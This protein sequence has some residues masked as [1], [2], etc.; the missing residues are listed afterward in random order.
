MKWN[1][2]RMGL[3]VALAF[4]SAYL[5]AF[6]ADGLRMS[7]RRMHL[8]E[9]KAEIQGRMFG[10]NPPTDEQLE[11]LFAAADEMYGVEKTSLFLNMWSCAILII[12]FLSG[13]WA[14]GKK[15]EQHS[16]QSQNMAVDAD[17]ASP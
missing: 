15:D 5:L 4:V 13:F 17:A 16:K 6:I 9:V 14:T 7:R 11:R 8:S 12:V 10:G 1:S 2:G 3:I